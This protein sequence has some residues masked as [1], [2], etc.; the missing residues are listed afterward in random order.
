[1]DGAPPIPT[2]DIKMAH[3]AP[4][5][6]GLASATGS[7]V[8]TKASPSAPPRTA[9]SA[10]ATWSTVMPPLEVAHIQSRPISAQLRATPKGLSSARIP[11]ELS[12]TAMGLYSAHS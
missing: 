2:V 4:F 12:E 8:A 9:S 3:Q 1:M 6:E 5:K 11:M 7:A 10:E